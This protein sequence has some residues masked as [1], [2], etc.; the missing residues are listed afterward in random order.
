MTIRLQSHCI[1][2][3]HL[4]P[5][6]TKHIEVDCHVTHMGYTVKKIA[7]PQIHSKEQ[8]VDVFTKGVFGFM[9][10]GGKWEVEKLISYFPCL[11]GTENGK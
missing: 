6:Q 11:I 3:N 2:T 8:V 9:K 7:L 4:F 1:A 10:V 5:E